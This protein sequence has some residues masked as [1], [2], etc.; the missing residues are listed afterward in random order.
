MLAIAQ[1]E[2]VDIITHN[3]IYK[4]LDDVKLRLSQMLP[5]AIE[6]HVTGE[7]TILK[8]FEINVRSKEFKPVAGCRVTDGMI[9]KNQKIRVMRNDQ[10]IWE[11]KITILYFSHSNCP[12][13]S[14]CAHS[15]LLQLFDF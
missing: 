10:Q 8:V 5:P 6:T 15:S 1:S 14:I 11:G 3:I 12:Y 13:L 2:H 4:L 7:A 9:S